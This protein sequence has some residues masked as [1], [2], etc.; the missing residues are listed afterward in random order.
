MKMLFFEVDKKQ[1][2]YFRKS[3]PHDEL[4]FYDYPLTQKTIPAAHSDALVI[5][6]FVHSHITKLVLERFQKLALLLSRTTGSDHIDCI[7]TQKRNICV[8]TL[9]LYATQAVAEYTFALL[10]TLLRKIIVATDHKQ[11]HDYE[12]LRGY[13]LAQ[14]KIGIIGFGMIGKAVASIAQAFSM[15]ILVYDPYCQMI[16]EGI[17]FVSLDELLQQTEIITVHAPLTKKTWHMLNK[18]TLQ[19]CK[20]G[21]FLINTA[22]GGIIDTLA[23]VEALKNNIFEG[24]A[25][26]VL[27]EESEHFLSLIESSQVDKE[28]YNVVLANE[29]LAQHPKVI[30]SPHNAFNTVEALDRSMQETYNCIEAWRKAQ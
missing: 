27:E 3:F 25:L 28:H 10:L 1:E 23:L 7:E 17:S 18:E 9:P 8:K 2:L 30:I 22:R 21:S 29:Y 12:T 15:K 14:K 4:Y 20:K 16:Q 19:R 26:D 13:E 11:K 6:I 5:S 24:V